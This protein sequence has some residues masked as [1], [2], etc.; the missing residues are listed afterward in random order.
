[1]ST[2][3]MDDVVIPLVINQT[4]GQEFRVNLHTSSI[5]EVNIYLED[6][7]LQTL[8]LLNE[9]DFVMTPT[10]D[11]S[12]AGRFYI[13]LTADTLS[14]EEVNTSLLNAYK[15]VD[16]NYI[17][18]EGLA[19]QSTSTEV[20]L[21]NILGTKV[22]DAT[23]DNTSNTQMISTNGLSTGIYVIKLESGQNQL[24]KKL[25]IK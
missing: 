12:D 13:H 7:E 5:G 25:I 18:I 1:M 17:T 6:T 16:S 4:S 15:E 2:D 9:E 20:S 19:T 21:F 8:T 24:T 22:M 14:N 23:L 11:L 10:S 3:H